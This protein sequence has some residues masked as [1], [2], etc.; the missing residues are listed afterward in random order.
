MVVRRNL[1]IDKERTFRGSRFAFA[2][3]RKKRLVVDDLGPGDVVGLEELGQLKACAC[4]DGDGG[5]VE[6][7]PLVGDEGLEGAL[8]GAVELVV[9][10]HLR[11]RV[12]IIKL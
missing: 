11:L 2:V 4:R 3:Y 10:H 12:Y 6:V 7:E 1:F 9:V 8:L 5:A